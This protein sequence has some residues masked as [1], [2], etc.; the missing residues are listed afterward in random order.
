[1]LTAHS[2]TRQPPTA[3]PPTALAT[4]EQEPGWFTQQDVAVA[5]AE[6]ERALPTYLDAIRWALEDELRTDERVVLLGEDIG[7]MGGAFRVTDGLHAQFGGERVIDTPMAET[8]IV[9]AGIGLAVAGMRPIV[10]LQFA[11]FISCA[12]DQLVSEAAKLHYRF[13]IAVP[14]VVRAPSG[15]GVGAGPFHSQSPEGVFA[16]IPGLKVVCPG[17]PQDAYDLLRLAVRDPNPVLY[18]EHK[19]LY[20]SLHGS[21]ERREPA[22]GDSLSRAAIRRSGTDVT[23]VTYGGMLPACLAAAEELDAEGIDVEVLDLRTVF[24]A[25]HDA[26]G[27]SVC[28]TGRLVVV[29][30]DTLSS[31]VGAEIA[32]RVAQDFFF[33]LDAPV[34]RVAAPD[35]PVPFAQ[36]LEGAYVP[37]TSRI[38]DTIRA[39][40][41][42]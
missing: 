12:Y 22:P 40:V 14:L 33:R 7:H 31:G 24:P 36:P 35:A 23:V 2:T 29:H 4:A 28:R 21:V 39:T 1:L 37:T 42:T 30:E 3:Q 17:D 8:A 20:R 11:D 34:A 19:G 9:G 5:A 13:G 32:A 10:E 25:D 41:A 26:V 15:G 38:A 16:H 6:H 18:F 27:E